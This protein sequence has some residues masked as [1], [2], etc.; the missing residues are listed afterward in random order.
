MIDSILQGD[1]REVL[2]QFEDN[3]FDAI[4]TDPPYELAF[5]GK[6]WD[7]SGI[8]YD[9]NVWRECLRVLKPG[10]HLLSFGGTRT[11]HR[12]ACAIEDAGFDI[13]DCISWCF[14]SGFPKSLDI[15]K[16][17]DQM[18]GAEREIVGPGKYESRQPNGLA[19]CNVTGFASEIGKRHGS[20][21]PETAPSTPAAK[22]WAG[23]G[24]SLKP[25]WEA[26]ILAQKPLNT[27]PYYNTLCQLK[28]YVLLVEQNLIHF[29]QKLQEEKTHIAVKSVPIPR[30]EE[31]ESLTETGKAESLPG[32]MDMYLSISE[33]VSNA[34]NTTS[35]WNGLLEDRL[36]MAN[37]STIS[38]A[39]EL[40][41]DQRILNSLIGQIT[42]LNSTLA[43]V[44]QADGEKQLVSPVEKYLSVVWSNLNS[45]QELFAAENA[46]RRGVGSICPAEG[47][48]AEHEFI[49]LARKPLACKTIA[50]NVLEWGC[51]GLN[52]DS[53]RISTTGIDQ[54]K[55]LKEWDR[56]Q[57]KGA[58]G[59]VSGGMGLNE[60]DLSSYAKPG[61]FPSNLIWSHSPLCKRIG[62]K[63]VKVNDKEHDRHNDNRDS[64]CYGKYN[65]SVT[66]GF[67]DADGMETVES[68]DCHPSCPT[69]E[70]A[71]AGESK[72]SDRLRHNSNADNH[73][74]YNCFGKYG[75]NITSGFS[76]QGTPA[77]FFKSC[78]Y[79]EEDIPA[80][81][82]CAKASRA[83]RERGLA[84]MPIKQRPG[85][86]DDDN[87]QW[88]ESK[89]HKVAK[90]TT[91]HHPTVKPLALMRYLC[92]L[93]TPPD[94][95]ILD[96]FSGSGTTCLAAKSEGFHF[97]GIEKEPEYVTIANKRLASIP[98]SLATYCQ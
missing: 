82:Y 47:G 68:W 33:M 42:L 38:T 8:A 54:E 15:S 81:H 12:M 7:A 87:Y 93:I 11:Y 69:W 59:N 27:V 63:K 40:I 78:S 43:S 53:C 9:I 66:K 92:R 77:R 84:G 50:E 79:T 86:F 80:F 65:P 48:K 88:D 26:V 58:K 95:L 34:L 76:D 96:P 45:I 41:T 24:T 56:L 97:V 19:S 3:Y 62:T 31:K 35:L 20:N 85:L 32:P 49:C 39:S 52:I 60:V 29:L 10:G 83:E 75:N 70:F 2:K 37:K 25:A 46:L 28:E 17:L 16:K 94:G 64:N 6:K 89:G 72:S 91:N 51:G 90:P 73:D 14:G 61:R 55:H 21:A 22:Q 44:Y 4:C 18:A 13:R 98:A 57:S 67:A 30:E 1:C 71:K 5:M 23:F 74:K 36:N